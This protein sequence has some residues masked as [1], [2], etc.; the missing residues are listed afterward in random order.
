[1][2]SL[3]ESL[4]ISHPELWSIILE[5]VAAADLASTSL[6]YMYHKP[7]PSPYEKVVASS[8][9]LVTLCKAT[10]DASPSSSDAFWQQL[11]LLAWTAMAGMPLPAGIASGIAFRDLVHQLATPTHFEFDVDDNYT[12][13][14]LPNIAGTK[15][16][17]HDAEMREL[18]KIYQSLAPGAKS[19]IKLAARAGRG[20]ESLGAVSLLIDVRSADGARVISR[21]L[22][23]GPRV[24]VAK[25]SP[26][27]P[28]PGPSDPNFM[29]SILA[30]L[31]EPR[32]PILYCGWSFEAEVPKGWRDKKLDATVAFVSLAAAGPKALPLLHH[33]RQCELFVDFETP[34]EDLGSPNYAKSSAHLSFGDQDGGP[35]QSDDEGADYPVLSIKR[36]AA[37]AKGY[38]VEVSL[39]VVTSCQIGVYKNNEPLAFLEPLRKRGL[40]PADEKRL[41]LGRG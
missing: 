15:P 7:A 37:T 19:H 8:R 9:K 41:G 2:S 10:R 39:R 34:G 23:G 38:E 22:H 4:C 6:R 11:A 30:G 27:P 20:F 3:L 1:M 16:I 28:M 12:P 40:I 18:Q 5:H 35:M 36:K 13:C 32:G 31:D 29:Q 25:P 17:Q 24:V 21:A 33:Q 26:K 14:H